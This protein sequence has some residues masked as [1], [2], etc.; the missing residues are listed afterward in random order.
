[1][2][3]APRLRRIEASPVWSGAVVVLHELSQHSVQVTT[4]QDPEGNCEAIINTP[5]GRRAVGGPTPGRLRATW[6][7]A[8]LSS[9]LPAHDPHG[10]APLDRLAVEGL[11]GKTG[12]RVT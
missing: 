4:G 5:N 1:M 10:V 7:P 8:S 2:P 11:T 3:V 12:L 9:P 6:V